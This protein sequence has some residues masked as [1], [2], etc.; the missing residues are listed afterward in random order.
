MSAAV[1]IA[2]GNNKLL[3]FAVRLTSDGGEVESAIM[4]TPTST[5]HAPVPNPDSK[6][7]RH[8]WR[9]QSRAGDIML[10]LSRAR[11]LYQIVQVFTRT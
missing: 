4:L 8:T 1:M 9:T 3:Y 7:W 10:L 5:Y 6:T 11:K 2:L